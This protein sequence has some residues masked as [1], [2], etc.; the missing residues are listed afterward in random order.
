MRRILGYA[1]A[2]RMETLEKE[3]A[4]LKK[5]GALYVYLELSSGLTPYEELEAF[6]ECISNL[7]AGDILLIP[8]VDRLHRDYTIGMHMLEVLE[9]M[10]VSVV[11]L[12]HIHSEL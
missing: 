2:N 1:R 3:F 9:E 11:F 7:N 10:R 5:S 4:V 6:G 8:S 12:N